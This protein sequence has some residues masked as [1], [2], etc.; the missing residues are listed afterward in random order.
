MPWLVIL[1]EERGE[2]G[3]V[4]HCVHGEQHLSGNWGLWKSS[5]GSWVTI[6]DA[7]GRGGVAFHRDTRDLLGCFGIVQS[8]LIPAKVPAPKD[9][10]FP[11]FHDR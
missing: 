6:R 11:I 4:S 9:T 2:E 5:P 7:E 1:G 10:H 8:A 3:L